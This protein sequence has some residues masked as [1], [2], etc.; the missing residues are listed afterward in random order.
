MNDS[1]GTVLV[2]ED[3]DDLR[4]LL[5][6]VLEDERYA[7]A[8]ASDGEAALRLLD[9]RDAPQLILLDMRMPRMGGAELARELRK[10]NP[11]PPPIIV[12]TAAEYASQRAHDI[13]AAGWLAKPFSIDELLATV[14][15]FVRP[16]A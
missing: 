7:V 4:E 8:T 1:R 15:R 11:A 9:T 14:R 10:R 5:Q 2:V 3:D 6:R 12:M 13:A 16:A